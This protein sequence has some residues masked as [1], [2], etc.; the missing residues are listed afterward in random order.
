M[1]KRYSLE[2]KVIVTDVAAYMFENDV[3]L[4]KA[5]EDKMVPKEMQITKDEFKEILSDVLSK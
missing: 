3:T 5:Y 2:Q 1:K 4:E